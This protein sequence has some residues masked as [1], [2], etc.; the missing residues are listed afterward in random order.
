[1]PST[2]SRSSGLADW[3]I[4]LLVLAAGIACCVAIAPATPNAGFKDAAAALAFIGIAAVGIERAIEGLFAVL[5]GRLGEWWPLRLVEAEISQFESATNDI[6]KPVT[7]QSVKQL[8]AARDQLVAAGKDARTIEQAL[9]DVNTKRTRLEKQLQDVQAKLPPGSAR[10]ARLGEI[11][12]AMADTLNQ[13]HTVAGQATSGAQ[14]ALRDAADLAD[15][16]SMIISSFSDNPARRVASLLLGA[17]FGCVLAGATGLNVFA[18]TLDG[19]DASAMLVA[20]KAGVILTGILIGMGSSPTHE[21]VRSLQAYKSAR[22]GSIPVATTTNGAPAPR[23]A[24]NE[25]FGPAGL[26][27]SGASGV[28]VAIRTVRR[29]G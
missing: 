17:A 6:L 29:T 11:Q 2:T 18:A 26:D 5:S 3:G 15:R 12:A 28:G 14:V 9:E 21:V 4:L 22:S 25:A 24:V 23:E 8:E 1:M 19:A 13:A 10:L 16:A 27:I 7:D 20:G